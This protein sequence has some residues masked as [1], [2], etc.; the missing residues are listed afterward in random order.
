MNTRYYL[1][2]ILSLALI[3]II[4]CACEEETV[5][6]PQG[7]NRFVESIFSEID[8]SNN[9]FY[10]Q[11][12]SQGGESI[13]LVMDI[14]EPQGDTLNQRPVIILA[15]GGGFI[16]GDKEGMAE[17]ASFYARFGY[18]TASIK[19]RLIDIERTR[20]TTLKGVVDAALDMRAAVRFFRK[21]ASTTNQY[22]I[23]PNNIFVG[24]FSAGAFTALHVGYINNE[25]ELVAMGGTEL[26]SYVNAQGGLE[27][28]SG[29]EGFSSNVKGV[30]NAAGALIKAD[31]L[32]N[33]EPA[34][35]S[36]HGTADNVV[37]FLEGE[38]DGTGVITQGS[39]LIHPI[40]D[41]ETIPNEL[42]ALQGGGHGAFEDC[43]DCRIN[44]ARF[45]AKQL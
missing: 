13:E 1:I 31:A 27:G 15:H 33:G 26:L 18:V 25:E 12:T 17:L 2:G 36:A 22:R 19:Y 35:Y 5:I 10:G 45:I 11:N 42:D 44:I 23:D 30:I 40:A 43:N 39:G 29:N 37:P 3:A 16:G 24:G 14:Y 9:V 4:I 28:N 32:N 38:S 20:E 8:V 6:E 7:S 21:D 41:Q 34:L